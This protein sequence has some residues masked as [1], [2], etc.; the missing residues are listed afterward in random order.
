MFGRGP[1]AR[2]GN[3]RSAI[4]SLLGEAPMNGY[5]IMQAIEQRSNGQW[6]PSSGSVYPTLQQLEDEDLVTTEPAPS[7][8]KVFKLTAKGKRYVDDNKDELASD[9]LPSEDDAAQ[10][11]NPKWELMNQIRQITMA[12]MQVTQTGTQKQIDDAKKLLAE[13]RR[14]LYRMLAEDDDG[15]D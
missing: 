4:L 9:W 3:V 14:A 12:V 6:K 7:G 2:R 1:R 15:E 11:A 10:S 8:S 5:Q 13:T